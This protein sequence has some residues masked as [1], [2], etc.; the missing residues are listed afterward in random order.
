MVAS[1][2]RGAGYQYRDAGSDLFQNWNRFYDPATGRYLEPEPLLNTPGPSAAVYAYANSSPLFSTDPTGLFQL[3]GSCDDWDA[4]VA[5]AQKWARCDCDN[6]KGAD[7]TCKDT[8]TFNACDICQFLKKG[9]PPN[10]YI[11]TLSQGSGHTSM[12][13]P[14]GPSTVWYHR[15]H[16]AIPL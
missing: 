7:K 12:L 16:K 5:N 14:Q 3:Q 8:M 11:D 1:T 4:A 9:A 10:A 6:L 13:V 15:R 2:L